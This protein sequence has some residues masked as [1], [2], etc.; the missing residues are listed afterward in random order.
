MIIQ[1]L[2]NS[3]IKLLCCVSIL[4]FISGILFSNNRS[5]FLEIESTNQ[6]RR[7]VEAALLDI[8]VCTSADRVRQRALLATLQTWARLASY[9][10]VQYWITFGTLVGYVQR[11]TL[12][13][14]DQDIDIL[15]M[16]QDTSQLVQIALNLSFQNFSWFDSNM[17]KLVIH[18]QWYIVNWKNRSYFPSHSITF[19]ALNARFF[20]RERNVF[21]DIWPMYDY[22]PEQSNHLTDRTPM[23]T[24]IGLNYRWVSSPKFWSF[25]LRPCD[26][27]GI[28]VWCPGEPEEIVCATYGREALY[29]SDTKCING[30]WV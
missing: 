8:P 19:K 12:L 17:Y 10:H 18:P 15:I 3:L 9:F 16:G 29:K 5:L 25:P 30:S 7:L 26:L 28:R 14:H 22:Y 4:S 11:R 6:S 2:S 13:P 27:S 21:V 1:H 20:H 23:L 24:S